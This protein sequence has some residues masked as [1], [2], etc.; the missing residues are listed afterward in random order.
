MK[1]LRWIYH[2][3]NGYVDLNVGYIIFTM[4]IRMFT[5]QL[6]GAIPKKKTQSLKNQT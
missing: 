3:Y 2:F 4:D 6:V 5:F 1:T